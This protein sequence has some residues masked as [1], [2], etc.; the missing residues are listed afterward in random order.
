MA[1]GTIA[2]AGRIRLSRIRSAPPHGLRGFIDGALPKR[3]LPREANVW[4]LKQLP[5]LLPQFLRVQFAVTV[6]R[7][8]G[9]RTMYGRTFL[10]STRNGV[11]FERGIGSYRVVTDT[12]VQFIVD[13]LHANATIANLKYHGFGTG[14]TAESAAQTTLVTECTTAYATD[15]TRPTGTQTEGASANI[16]RTVGTLTPDA[17]VAL[18]EHSVFDQAANSGGTMLDR[19]K[20]AAVNL[21]AASGDSEA[22]TYELTLPSGS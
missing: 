10:V 4:R 11:T 1:T 14:T 19:S 16:Y 13:A 3:S 21:I 8:C 7:L 12:G 20:F 22:V 15:N 17:D 9:V 5:R 2:P 18:T 6:G